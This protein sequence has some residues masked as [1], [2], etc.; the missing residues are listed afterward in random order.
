MEAI[1]L[2][3]GSSVALVFIV[4][5]TRQLIE[6]AASRHWRPVRGTVRRVA[7]EQHIRSGADQFSA[8]VDYEY[9]FEG[10]PHRNC[11][12]VGGTSSDRDEVVNFVRGYAAGQQ[13]DVFVDPAKPQKS[14]LDPGLKYGY[15]VPVMFG[16]VMLAFF[17]SRFFAGGL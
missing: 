17:V 1:G 4:A 10:A 6:G 15:L 9:M 3:I 7:I 11:Q 14:T 5:F 12:S 8:R 16:I 2:I 13:V